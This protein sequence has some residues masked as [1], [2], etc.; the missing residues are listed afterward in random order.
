MDFKFRFLSE[1]KLERFSRDKYLSLLGTYVND[2]EH[3]VL[4]MGPLMYNFSE[5]FGSS[6]HNFYL[7]CFWEF[8][9]IKIIWCIKKGVEYLT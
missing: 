4:W 2:E 1:T 8:C 6:M 7:Y 9:L 5:S 3:D